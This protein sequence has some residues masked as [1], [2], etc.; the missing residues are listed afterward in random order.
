[1]D[2]TEE[3]KTA[4]SVK[5]SIARQT[6]DLDGKIKGFAV[7]VRRMD[8]GTRR[9]GGKIDEDLLAEFRASFLKSKGDAAICRRSSMESAPGAI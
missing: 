5:E 3:E 6:A 1:V 9:F 4:A 8:Q 7:P 2:L